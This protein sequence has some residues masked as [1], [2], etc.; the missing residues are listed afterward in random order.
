MWVYA[1]HSQ[2]RV[3]PLRCDAGC[4]QRVRLGPT[5]GNYQEVYAFKA[6]IQ[7][8]ADGPHARHTLR[9]ARDKLVCPPVFRLCRFGLRESSQ[10]F[11][12]SSGVPADDDDVCATLRLSSQSLR[13]GLTHARCATN[14]D[15]DGDVVGA[16]CSIR[17]F[18]DGERGHRIWV[19]LWA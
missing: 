13:H 19:F 4:G 16:E 5:G 2:G 11:R 8:R 3:E 15:G 6:G 10:N 18:D 14:E 9:L 7:R 17:G 1:P 12:S